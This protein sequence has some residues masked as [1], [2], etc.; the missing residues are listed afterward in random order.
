MELANDLLCYN[1][2]YYELERE[3]LK[4]DQASKKG[5][6]NKDKD[7]SLNTSA[8]IENYRERDNNSLSI[9]RKMSKYF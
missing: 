7:N 2:E 5:L 4:V 1:E 9:E 3:K 6:D 8:N